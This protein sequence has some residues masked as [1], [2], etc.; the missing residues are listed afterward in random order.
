M[1]ARSGWPLAALA[2]GADNHYHCAPPGECPSVKV[3]GAQPPTAEQLRII[4]ERG[5]G[6]EIIRGAADGGK[7]MTALLRLKNLTDMFRARHVRLN[8]N[9][10]VRVL[11]LTYNR[12][13]CGYVEALA[14]ERISTG[15]SVDM[16]VETFAHWAWELLSRPSMVGNRDSRIR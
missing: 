7:T 13:L 10:P 2:R 14:S 9:R 3:L 16:Q 15:T 4:G 8:I 5:P 6:V 1:A 12:T 11:V